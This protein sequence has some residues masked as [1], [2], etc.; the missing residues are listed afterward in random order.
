MVYLSPDVRKRETVRPFSRT[1]RMGRRSMS[2]PPTD[3]LSRRPFG[4]LPRDVCRHRDDDMEIDRR[5][6]GMTGVRG[7][8]EG[9]QGLLESTRKNATASAAATAA[10]AQATIVLVSSSLEDV[11]AGVTG[12]TG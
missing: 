11:L 3:A 12:T 5:A 9:Y 4:H 6:P 2:S 10:A 1:M 7:F 8:T